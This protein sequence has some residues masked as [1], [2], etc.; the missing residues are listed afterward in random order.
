MLSFSATR[1]LRPDAAQMLGGV[2]T[3]PSPSPPD[4]RQELGRNTHSGQEAGRG[5]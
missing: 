4:T 5:L 1:N 3:V 2:A